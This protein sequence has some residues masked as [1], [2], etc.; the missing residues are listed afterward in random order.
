MKYQF[1]GSS[2]TFSNHMYQVVECSE[3]QFYLVLNQFVYVGD[4]SGDTSPIIC[5]RVMSRRNLNPR[6]KVDQAGR[7]LPPKKT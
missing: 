1:Q 2:S 4:V 7:P 5:Q 3:E 6:V